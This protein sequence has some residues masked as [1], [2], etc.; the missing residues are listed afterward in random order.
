ML[1]TFHVF[2]GD[3]VTAVGGTTDVDPESGAKFSGGGF[4]NYFPRPRYQL[5]VV[6]AYLEQLG[7]QNRGL[8]RCVY[9]CDL[10]L[11]M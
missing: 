4:S 1:T 9:F 11:L 10:T 3:F 7:N 2:A 8:Y 6:P 5:D